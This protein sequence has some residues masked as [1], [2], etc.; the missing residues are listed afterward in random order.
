M[1]Y[2][3]ELLASFLAVM[4][5]IT[6]HEFAHAFVAYKCGD[7]TPKMAGRLSVNPVKHFDL[8]GIFT[9]AIVGFG[10]AKP[11]PVNPYNFK[12]G[13][14]GSFF[15]SI[16]GVAINLL[17]AF[18]FYPIMHLVFRYLLPETY[19]TYMFPFLVALTS[20]LYGYS[21]SFSVFNLLPFFPL[22]GFRMVDSLNKRRGKIYMFLRNYGYY[23]LLAL[24]LVHILADFTYLF[25]YIDLLGYFMTF[26][27]DFL[28]FPI[29]KFWGLF[30]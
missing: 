28:G 23:V 13:K 9:F 22:D 5:V 25:A 2:F 16:A 27:I 12:N 26:A 10:W 24:M 30:L 4:V 20:Y 21:L 8:V 11:V 14:W 7:P 17:F 19:G 6:L 1:E 15:T 29:V 3:V 18:L